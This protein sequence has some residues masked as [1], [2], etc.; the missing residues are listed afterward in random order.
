MTRLPA[1]STRRGADS[2]RRGVSRVAATVDLT[3]QPEEAPD[4]LSRGND[5]LR[6]AA[7]SGSAGT[8]C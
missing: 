5:H 8:F 6:P 1:R 3:N 2:K 4:R 7:I